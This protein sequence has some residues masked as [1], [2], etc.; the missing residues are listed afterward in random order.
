MTILVFIEKIGIFIYSLLGKPIVKTSESL[1]PQKL[2]RKYLFCGDRV[3]K[4]EG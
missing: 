1:N 3:L 2:F 4:E